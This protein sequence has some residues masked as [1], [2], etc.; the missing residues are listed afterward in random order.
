MGIINSVLKAI[1]KGDAVRDYQHSSRTF[2][3]NE[4]ELHPRLSN[5][6]HVIFEF[7][8]EAAGLFQNI[9]KLEMSL[10][11]K[12][13]QLPTFTINVET[14]NQY[15]RQVHSQHK[16]NYS[17]V[18]I[19]FH[20]DAADRVLRLWTEY[21]KF[22]YADSIYS[23]DLSAYSTTDRYTTRSSNR[24]G[25]D[26]GQNRFFRSIKVYS[27][28][29]KKFSEYTLINPMIQSFNH[30]QHAYADSNTLEHTMT[31]TYETVKYAT[32]RVSRRHPR[33]F[34]EI[35]YDNSPSPIGVFGKGPANSII[36]Q[37]GLLAAAGTV[38]NDLSTG[39]I[40][41]AIGKGAIIFSNTRNSNLKDSL[42][43]DAQRVVGKILRGEN[44]LSGTVFPTGTQSKIDSTPGINP[45][46][47]DASDAS[48]VGDT[49]A[50]RVISEHKFI[51]FVNR[52][53]SAPSRQFNVDNKRLQA[54]PASPS[55]KTKLSDFLF[56][57][58]RIISF[59]DSDQKIL[60]LR[61][62]AN[63]IN[64]QIQNIDNGLDTVTQGQRFALTRE[65]S[66]IQERIRLE[67]GKSV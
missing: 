51:D 67:S 46:A 56:S 22:Y 61:D 54:E 19:T 59:T 20:D 40:L 48:A 30:G 57:D 13:I 1:E 66:S 60:E 6:F 62:R 25:L 49:S 18:T 16:I 8:P 63:R 53:L 11:V 28:L 27:M 21:Y 58:N 23:Q 33:G 14:H 34:G 3:A 31:I 32:G 5:L 43:K 42:F 38:L 24:W 12:S 10:L 52:D 4:F 36:G 35:H 41:G 47:S 29:D 44:P 45:N 7:T 9:E 2:V 65:L 17:P 55:H 37:N 26:Y 64:Q 39:N 50:R 15:N